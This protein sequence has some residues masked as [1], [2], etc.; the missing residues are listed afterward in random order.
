MHAA[1]YTFWGA[2]WLPIIL[3]LILVITLTFVFGFHNWHWGSVKQSFK[4]LGLAFS[5]FLARLGIDLADLFSRAV[6]LEGCF[7]GGAIFFGLPLRGICFVLGLLWDSLKACR[8]VT[9]WGY[10]KVAQRMPCAAEG[11]SPPENSSELE[12]SDLGSDEV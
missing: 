8:A 9:V 7:T 12:F 5:V 11:A 4:D 1:G 3:C 2:R 6:G 10:N